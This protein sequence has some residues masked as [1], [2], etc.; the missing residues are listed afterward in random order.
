MGEGLCPAICER[1][2]SRRNSNNDSK[3]TIWRPNSVIV[4]LVLFSVQVRVRCTASHHSLA[5]TRVSSIPLMQAANRTRCTFAPL[6]VC[7]DGGDTGA[8]RQGQQIDSVSP[9]RGRNTD[10]FTSRI[11]SRICSNSICLPFL[12]YHSLF[13]ACAIETLPLQRLSL[14]GAKPFLIGT[15]TFLAVGCAAVVYGS[16]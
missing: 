4:H 5:W 9:G 10:A 7:A 2:S 3:P 6:Y 11:V 8:F 1:D 16:A 12:I 15:F 14:D 13:S